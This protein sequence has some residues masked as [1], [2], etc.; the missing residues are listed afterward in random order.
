M[1]N[2]WQNDPRLK[3]MDK[4]KLQLLEELAARVG[5]AD[6]SKLMDAFLSVQLEAREKGIQFNDR[7]TG[8]LVSILSAHMAPK[9]RKKLELLKMLSKRLGG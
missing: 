5:Q 6:K 8:L 9:E 3:A 4:E 1:D 2:S 7:E